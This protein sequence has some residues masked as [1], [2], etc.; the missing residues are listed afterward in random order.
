MFRFI[1]DTVLLQVGIE[2]LRSQTAQ[3]L[4]QLLVVVRSSEKV[5]FA[6]DLGICQSRQKLCNTPTHHR[7]EHAANA[8]HIQAVVILPVADK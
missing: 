1:V 3:D 2:L 4:E 6:E 5:L 8:P 7:G